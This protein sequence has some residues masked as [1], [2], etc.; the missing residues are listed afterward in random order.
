MQVMN[1]S[2]AFAFIIF[3]SLSLLFP[4]QIV[5]TELGRALTGMITTFWLLR[6]FEQAIFFKLK[7]WLSRL[8]TLVFLM[9]AGFTA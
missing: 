9:G 4:Q 1:L 7:H 6:A 5:E 8:F 3:G 2:L